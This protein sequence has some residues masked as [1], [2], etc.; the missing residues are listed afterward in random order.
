MPLAKCARCK[1]MFNKIKSAVCPSCMP[2]E[3]TEYDLIR[4]TIRDNPDMNAEGVAA[5]SGVEEEV[6]HRMLKEG[7]ISST[8]LNKGTKCG[9]CGGEA[10]SA[11]K[12]LCQ[13][14]L[15]KLN[16]QVNKA[17]ASIR[18][19]GKKEAQVGEFLNVRQTISDKKRK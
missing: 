6:V 16:N 10:I 2:Q 8:A 15:D 14:C 13:P 5:L 11:A 3:E 4:T 12:K 19:D 17:R 7:L 9:M 1:K 18:L